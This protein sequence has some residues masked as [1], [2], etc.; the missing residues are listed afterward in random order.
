M[1]TLHVDMKLKTGSA[2][3]LRSTYHGAFRPAIS[4]QPGFVGV[5][6]LRSRADQD[7][8]RLVIAFKSELDQQQWVATE[9]HQQ[10]WPAMEAHCAAIVVSAFD[11]L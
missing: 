8:Y 6:L 1:F 11:A 9:L 10:V 5:H 3:L 4:A 7:S 2:E